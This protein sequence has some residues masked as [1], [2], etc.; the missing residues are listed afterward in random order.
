MCLEAASKIVLDRLE[1]N[2][3][4]LL[5][6]FATDLQEEAVDTKQQRVARFVR[7][8]SRTSA[9]LICD[10]FGPNPLS[11]KPSEE[12][13]DDSGEDRYE[14][15]DLQYFEESIVNIQAFWKLRENLQQFFQPFQTIR[16]QNRE[17]IVRD[18]LFIFPFADVDLDPLSPNELSRGDT[19]KALL[20]T[21]IRKKNTLM[22]SSLLAKN[23]KRVTWTCVS[24]CLSVF[25]ACFLEA[26]TPYSS[27]GNAYATIMRN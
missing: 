5:N 27:A 19:L 20:K 22:K 16:L 6:I 11:K 3:R 1:Q 4:R 23:M 21:L 15:A 9:W 2:L 14:D 18:L 17:A 10:E 25:A 24:D 8:H 12:A 7:L 26:D 13:S